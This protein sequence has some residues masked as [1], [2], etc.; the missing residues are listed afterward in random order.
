[1]RY[2]P[3]DLDNQQMKAEMQWPSMAKPCYFVEKFPG[4]EKKTTPRVVLLN[5]V[6]CIGHR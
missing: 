5:P 1:M 3:R 4:S 2:E 6:S